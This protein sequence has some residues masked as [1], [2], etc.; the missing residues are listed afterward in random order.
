MPSIDT[1]TSTLKREIRTMLGSIRT[2]SVQSLL[3]NSSLCP[4]KLPTLLLWFSKQAPSLMLSSS[5]LISFL[6]S[7]L[8]HWLPSTC[9]SPNHLPLVGQSTPTVS[10]VFMFFAISTIAPSPDISDRTRPWNL[11]AANTPGQEYRLS[12]KSISRHALLV[13]TQRFQG[14]SHMDS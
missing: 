13:H 3:R 6:L 10:S 2:T 9:P 1:G 12:S 14:I 7:P 4:Y 5:M 11:Y 8:I